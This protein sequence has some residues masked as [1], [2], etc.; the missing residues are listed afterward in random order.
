MTITNQL[1]EIVL[2]K[3]TTTKRD[4]D[5]HCIRYVY[6]KLRYVHTSSA[7]MFV[8]LIAAWLFVTGVACHLRLSCNKTLFVVETYLGH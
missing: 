8:Q 2:K 4:P 3:P 6:V 7:T 1:T 5:C